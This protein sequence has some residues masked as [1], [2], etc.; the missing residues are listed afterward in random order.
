M[1]SEQLWH[2]ML[3]YECHSYAAAA[4]KV[5]MSAQGLTK[6]IR[7]LERELERPLFSPDDM[8]SPEPTSYAVELYEFAS[9]T[10]SNVRLLEE[11]FKRIDGEQDHEIRLGCSLG[12]MGELGP[13]FLEGFHALEPHIRVLYWETN[14]ELCEEGLK[15]ETYDIALM[16]TPFSK[17]FTGQELFRCPVYFWVNV[18]D[19]LASHP[20]L[21]LEDLSDRNIAIPGE[22]FKCYERLIDETSH[23][24]IEVQRIFQMSEIFHIYEFAA[25]NRGLGFT[26]RN[27]IG[28]SMFAHDESVVAI[29]MAES[30]WG[31]G[32]GR[33]K[34]HALSEHER[35]F[36][37]WCVSY[38]ARL[39][40]DPLE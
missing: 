22:G 31:F 23:K 34:T 20:I 18:N 21:T 8:G 16:V 4:R 5:P 6:S 25:S 38:A 27:Q 17:D 10:R 30:E 7:T 39:P 12:V 19:P 28:L 9:V 13:D 37:D 33:L 24:G 1:N 14:D 40:S 2:F 29:P 15:K 11:A 32:I 3:V 35:A 36:W 26:A